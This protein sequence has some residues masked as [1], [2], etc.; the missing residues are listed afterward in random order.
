[1]EKGRAIIDSHLSA[2]RDLA[3][4]DD[5]VRPCPQR[6]PNFYAKAEDRQRVRHPGLS[7]GPSR[8][9]YE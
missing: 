8:G 6:I 9:H 1:M 3:L 4:Y 7:V 2:T 5:K